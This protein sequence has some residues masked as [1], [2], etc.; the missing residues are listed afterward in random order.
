MTAASIV[1]VVNQISCE[2]FYLIMATERTVDFAR[3]SV[4]LCTE[5]KLIGNRERL[6]KSSTI[7]SV[8]IVLYFSLFQ[9]LV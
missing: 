9:W 3:F 2:R 8:E 1:G 5:R 6:A 4:C 7:K